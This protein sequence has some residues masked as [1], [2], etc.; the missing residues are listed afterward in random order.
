MTN[1]IL[2]LLPQNDFTDFC[3][4]PN[5]FLDSDLDDDDLQ[6]STSNSLSS[7]SKLKSLKPLPEVNEENDKIQTEISQKDEEDMDSDIISNF[8]YQNSEACYDKKVE[9]NQISGNDFEDFEDES[10]ILASQK[11]SGTC[12]ISNNNENKNDANNNNDSNIPTANE[13]INSNIDISND[14][15][16]GTNDV[17]I[18]VSKDETSI[19]EKQDEDDDIDNDILSDGVNEME[20]YENKNENVLNQ[21]HVDCNMSSSQP[22][23]SRSPSRV[24]FTKEVNTLAYLNF[25]RSQMI[26]DLEKKYREI[27]EEERLLKEEIDNNTATSSNDEEN[28][29]PFIP[30]LDLSK[31]IPTAKLPEKYIAKQQKKQQ[32][33][34]S[35]TTKPKTNAKS[36]ICQCNNKNNNSHKPSDPV[37]PVI[38]QNLTPNSHI[39]SK[40][41]IKNN[42]RPTSA[43]K[44]ETPIEEPETS[45]KERSID[46]KRE[47]L[48]N[49]GFMITFLHSPKISNNTK[50]STHTV[51][52]IS[53]VQVP[54]INVKFTPEGVTTTSKTN[55]MESISSKKK[56]IKPEPVEEESAYNEEELL[57][58]IEHMLDTHKLPPK[59]SHKALHAYLKKNIF[60]KII[61]QDYDEAE[62]L[63][64]AQDLLAEEA[65]IKSTVTEKKEIVKSINQRIEA[66]KDKLFQAKNEWEAKMAK[67]DEE[68][69][70][71]QKEL[72]LKQ[73]EE[74]EQFEKTWN[75][76][77][78]LMQFNK[79]S[80]ALIEIRKLQ[81]SKALS[82]DFAGAKELKK[83]GDYLEKEETKRAEERATL[84]MKQS[85]EKLVAKH[86]KE[87]EYA[88]QNWQRQRVQYESEKDHEI[89]TIE[90]ALKQLQNKL[91]ESKSRPLSSIGLDKKKAQKNSREVT[92][93]TTPRTRRQLA[94]F[95]VAPRQERL[96][97]NT[98]G[99]HN[100]VK[101]KN[102]TARFANNNS[103]Q[104]AR[105]YEF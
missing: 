19:I 41:T 86:K 48:K 37:I 75:N 97:I 89:H 61:D 12:S 50:N 10:E 68:I 29:K 60:K 73:N 23:K 84:S 27:E 30:P 2:S 6:I 14:Q 16:N 40:Q 95:K 58:M 26:S 100:Y 11:L 90:L 74:L 92:T 25:T 98:V 102:K 93:P 53:K 5:S 94:D 99:V 56:I 83:R 57:G 55:N 88:K 28:K 59:E 63:K 72:E 3:Y 70:I 78:T 81:R 52:M 4:R 39:K 96:Q 105:R 24:S 7:F 33:E 85:Y 62:R 42:A 46:D 8:E 101:S 82:G 71:K 9:D 65:S 87:V 22:V 32:A 47:E 43:L 18:I 103:R 69:Q 44:H 45:Q 91:N 21:Q 66:T 76:P 67:F 13:A 17:E 15:N 104:S 49:N 1:S 31:S 34:M 38:N 35:K 54:Q 36:M 79:P 64:E 51:P 80:A 20:P 77:E